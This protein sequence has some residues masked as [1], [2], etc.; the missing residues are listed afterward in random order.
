MVGTWHYEHLGD[1]QHFI[2]QLT[3]KTDGTFS[4]TRI[5]QTRSL[6][7]ID[8]EEQYTYWEDVDELSGGFTAHGHSPIVA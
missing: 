3:F 1:K 7:T 4:G 5:W 2:E 8:G 6:V